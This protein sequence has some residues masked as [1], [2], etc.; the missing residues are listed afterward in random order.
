MVESRASPGRGWAEPVCKQ[1]S[2]WARLA[3]RGPTIESSS[4]SADSIAVSVG[5]TM[6]VC[7]I[8]L[9]TRVI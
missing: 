9:L 2:A 8:I 4:R 6:S 3:G 5:T 7:P 1:C